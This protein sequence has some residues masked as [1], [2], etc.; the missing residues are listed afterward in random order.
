M[1]NVDAKKKNPAKLQP[2][3]PN[4]NKKKTT[5]TPHPPPLPK[6]KNP[7]INSKKPTATRT[8]FCGQYFFYLV[9]YHPR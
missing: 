7:K 4:K 6:K 1:Y 3:P 8:I 9:L 2:P 5:N